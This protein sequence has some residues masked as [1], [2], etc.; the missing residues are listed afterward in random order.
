LPNNG[1]HQ[2]D[3]LSSLALTECDRIDKEID[4]IGHEQQRLQHVYRIFNVDM[5]L[6]K[7]LPLI[8][9]VSIVHY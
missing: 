8:R 7:D 6:S 1:P 5:S 3:M 4:R 2:A 9:K